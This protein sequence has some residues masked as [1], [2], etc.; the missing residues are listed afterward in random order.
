MRW[1]KLGGVQF[2]RLP[3][4]PRMKPTTLSRCIANEGSRKLP[5]Q[6]AKVAGHGPRRAHATPLARLVQP[7]GRQGMSDR[8]PTVRR[9]WVFTL[10]VF[11]ISAVSYFWMI[12]SGSARDVGLIWMWSPGLAAVLTQLIF[13][14][15]LRDFGWGPGPARYLILAALIPVGYSVAIYGI[16]W[17]TGLAGF[18]SPSPNLVVAVVPGLLFA[19]FA[20]LGEEIGWRGF[21]VPQLIKITTF[22]KTVLLSWIIWALWHYPAIIW[23][24]YHSNA[25]RWFGVVSLTLTLVGLSAMTAWMRLKSGSVWPPVIW[26]GTHNLLVQGVFLSMT[27]DTDIGGYLV[28][29]FGLGVMVTGLLLALIFLWK[30]RNIGELGE[31]ATS[32]TG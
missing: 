4:N 1:F 22:T 15:S 7:I 6:S 3:P 25:P 13:N 20:A 12:S 10:L 31:I 14:G 9:L 27:I 8:S 30:G 29:D 26:H 23:A 2:G 24:D 21:L 17:T 16:V 19:C 18:Q 5:G 28:D 11:S 32:Q